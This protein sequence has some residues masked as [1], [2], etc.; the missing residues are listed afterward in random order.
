MFKWQFVVAVNVIK[1]DLTAHSM[2]DLKVHVKDGSVLTEL[3]VGAGE[4][5]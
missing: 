5:A 2:G 1:R 3:H 4:A